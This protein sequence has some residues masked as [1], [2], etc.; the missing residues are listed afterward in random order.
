MEIIVMS[1]AMGWLTGFIWVASTWGFEEVPGRL[2]PG[3]SGMEAAFPASGPSFADKGAFSSTMV[4]LGA[5]VAGCSG[6][7]RTDVKAGL[8]GLSSVAHKGGFS[9]SLSSMIPLLATRQHAWLIGISPEEAHESSSANSVP[10]CNR[11]RRYF[12]ANFKFGTS[13]EEVLKTLN[14]CKSLT[15]T[16]AE[17]A[18]SGKS[19]LSKN[20]TGNSRSIA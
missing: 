20:R 2:S 10:C 4:F 18:P 15:L 12:F 16:H 5:L 1:S 19:C 8:G 6:S 13:R 7:K 17:E 14:S 3:V 9:E 11:F